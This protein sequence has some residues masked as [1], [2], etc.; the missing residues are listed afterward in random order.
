MPIY[1][2][3]FNSIAKGVINQLLPGHSAVVKCFTPRIII[4]IEVNSSDKADLDELLESRGILYKDTSP[5]HLESND[6]KNFLDDAAVIEDSLTHLCGRF[7]D[8]QLLV[9][10]REIYNDAENPI[11]DPSVK[12]IIGPGGHLVEHAGRINN[13]EIIHV[14]N[15]W[16]AQLVKSA[17]Y[18]KPDDLLIYYG[19]L[20]SFNSAVNQWNNELVAQEMAKYS[21]LVFGDGLQNPAH[22][23]YANTQIIIP[24]IKAL[25]P[26]ALIF[27]YVAV[28]QLLAAFEEKVDQW[29]DLG[30]HGIFMD[31]AGYDF[32]K[33]R[34]EFNQRVDYV[35]GLPMRCFAN[36]WNMDHVIGTANDPAYPNSTFNPQ[37]VASSLTAD[38]WYLLESFPINTMAYAGSGGYEPKADWAARGVKAIG[39]RYTYGIN[40]AASGVI[41]DDNVNGQTLFNFLFISSLMFS[42]EASGSS[43]TLCGSG[44]SNTK[45]WTRPD[46][47]KLVGCWSISP[48]VQVDAGDA[49]VYLRFLKG[50]KLKLDFSDSAQQSE[51][52]VF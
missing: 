40:L 49:D 34:A 23:D 10:R 35:H 5:A 47:Y 41:N 32:G 46:V 14:K 51:I 38:D 12:P 24:R 25:N 37:L 8:M 44:T 48:S 6:I 15:G 22:G 31:C 9:L 13:L 30:V 29:D 36:C 2:Y 17:G 45:W 52:I 18:R 42:V 39:H 3:Y 43:D 27:G 4:D 16:H 50:G 26:S 33:T 21:V 1:R 28:D 20:N 19:W 7:Q 11:Y